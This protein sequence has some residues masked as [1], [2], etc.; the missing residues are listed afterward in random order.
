[1]ERR[2]AISGSN[3]QKDTDEHK[4]VNPF[5]EVARHFQE[6]DKYDVFAILILSKPER[7]L[8]RHYQPTAGFDS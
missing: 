2:S 4:R 1:M 5:S 6:S 7:K 8:K 3:E